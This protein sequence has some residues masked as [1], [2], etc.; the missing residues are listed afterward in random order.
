MLFFK[1]RTKSKIMLRKYIS[2][3]VKTFNVIYYLVILEELILLLKHHHS[4]NRNGTIQ[5]L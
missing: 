3:S 5:R 2:D 4:N 1:K